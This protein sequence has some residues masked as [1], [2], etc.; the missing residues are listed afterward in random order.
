M[1]DET[2]GA[3]MAQTTPEA[4][5]PKD[6]PQALDLAAELAK[7]R[8]ELKEVNRESASRRKRLEELETA[9]AKKKES[10]MSEIE[11]LTK[12]LSET[13][14]QLKQKSRAEMVRAIADKTGLP[15]A[16]AARLHGET[17]EELET[18][19]KTLLEALP[20][21]TQ[22]TPNLNPTNPSAGKQGESLD[23]QLARIHGQQ[24]NPFD[25]TFAAKQG[26]GVFY[27]PKGE[28][29]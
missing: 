22:K 26:G 17:P 28:D 27:V 20:K 7:V 10:E 23:Q 8:A 18:D 25:P 14:T 11:K 13:E 2:R 3:E 1:A 16:L 12:R 4:E 6:A 19:A 9:E 21:P 29:K 5:K 15:A 24:V